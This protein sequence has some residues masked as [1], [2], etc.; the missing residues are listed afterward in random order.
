MQFLVTIPL[1][2]NGK[3]SS[4][5]VAHPLTRLDETESVAT[6]DFIL[7]EGIDHEGR[8]MC[9]EINGKRYDDPVTEIVKLGSI[10]I[11]RFINNT[12]DAHPMHVH[13]V[14]FQV[15]RR[16]G[17]NSVALRSGVLELVGKLR[18]PAA[19]EAGWK[20]TAVVNPQEVLTIIVRFEK[21]T[22]RYAFHSHI[23]EHEDNE[24]MRPFEVVLEELKSPV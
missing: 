14:Q 18:L 12:E 9:M 16:Q 5:Q 15:L 19:N 17:F 22:G 10:E 20:D 21:Y 6:R 11:W 24:M 8:G 2:S 1:S 23:L 13:M 4:M 3:S 7:S